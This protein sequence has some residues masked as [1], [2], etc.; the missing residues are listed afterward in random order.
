MA[1][2]VDSFDKATED[3]YKL[4]IP[5]ATYAVFTT[6]EVSEEE[7]VDS[8]KGTWSYILQQWFPN[9]QYEIDES[10]FD[11]EYYDE[12]CHPWEFDKVSMKIYIP[13]KSI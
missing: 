4:E 13:I 11:F 6:P 9:S 7:F 10:K 1:V 3:M 8:I 5:A 12:H 2:G